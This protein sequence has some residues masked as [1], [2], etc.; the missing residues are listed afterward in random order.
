[1]DREKVKQ[2]MGFALD[3]AE[4]AEQ[5]VDIIVESLSLKETPIPKKI[6][7][8]FAVSDI[9]YNSSSAGVRN[10]SAYRS[11]YGAVH[12]ANLLSNGHVCLFAMLDWTRDCRCQ[13]DSSG[14]CQRSSF[15]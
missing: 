7:R 4:S 8:L 13:T 5:V 14:G 9:L 15:I 1:M 6:A 12:F 3:H 2:V 10:A 11:E